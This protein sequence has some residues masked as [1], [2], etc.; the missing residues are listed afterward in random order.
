M[1]RLK[2]E[3]LKSV[4]L[5]RFEAML[6]K[7]L[8]HENEVRFEQESKAAKDLIDYRLTSPI[9]KALGVEIQGY[10]QC[11]LSNA[12]LQLKVGSNIMKDT[13]DILS[14]VRYESLVWEPVTEN[15]PWGSVLGKTRSCFAQFGVI[16]LVA[17]MSTDRLETRFSK[18]GALDSGLFTSMLYLDASFANPQKTLEFDSL[19]VH[20]REMCHHI[21]GREARPLLFVKHHNDLINDLKN[22]G[23]AE[24]K[25]VITHSL[26][27]KKRVRT[28]QT[29]NQFG[30]VQLLR[31][32]GSAFITNF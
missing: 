22:E 28:F 8:E 29:Y 15:F 27:I 5:R 32:D 1:A 23:L 2:I 17:M 9:L 12:G 26:D 7:N 31:G 18:I 24:E 10:E 16:R 13:S 6:T 4:P 25:L 14:V 11:K 3:E 21:L 30:R 20:L 19:A